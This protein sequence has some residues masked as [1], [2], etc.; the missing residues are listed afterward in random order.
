MATLSEE[1][2]LPV[3]GLQLAFL[4]LPGLEHLLPR[5]PQGSQPFLDLGTGTCG[6]RTG[7]SRAD[8]MAADLE[9]S[10]RR[11]ASVARRRGS[12]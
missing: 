8:K 9:G 12:V 7:E 11:E 6:A 3:H 5:I 10:P 4:P 1:E 2:L